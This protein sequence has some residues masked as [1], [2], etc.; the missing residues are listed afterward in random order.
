MKAKVDRNKLSTDLKDYS[1]VL[2]LS[3]QALY[4][5]GLQSMALNRAIQ[6]VNPVTNPHDADLLGGILN[7]L[8]AIRDQLAD[9][10]G[11]DEKIVF[12]FSEE[13]E[14]ATHEIKYP[15]LED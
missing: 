11:V 13:E 1:V 3:D 6:E 2:T 9:K 5:L 8:D 12:P 4:D 10:D 7:A 15:D 14:A